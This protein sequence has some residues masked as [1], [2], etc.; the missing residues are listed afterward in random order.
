EAAE[1][2]AE[3]I[4]KH[5][6]GSTRL[7]V[8]VLPFLGSRS[9]NEAD[10]AFSLSQ[11]IAG[12]LARFRWFDVI[13]PVSLMRGAPLGG[14]N[15]EDAKHKELDYIVDGALTGDG[16]QFQITVRLL[17]LTAYASPVWSDR[18]ELP[19]GQLHRLDEMVTARIVARI[20]PV[21]LYIEGRQKRRE[22]Y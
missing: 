19:I 5:P 3:E 6:N 17:D 16:K 8:G 2:Q 12:A 1:P 20:D 13:A 21:I 15:D 10:L 11:E 9:S 14:P 22:H 18:L 7:R 4:T